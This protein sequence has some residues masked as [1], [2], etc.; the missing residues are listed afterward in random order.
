MS[1][2]ESRRWLLYAVLAAAYAL[3]SV[4]RLST[5]VLA[6][7]LQGAFDATGAELGTLHA[8]FF[9][10]YAAFQLPS[11]VVADRLG[12]RWAVAGGTV[13][14]SVGGLVFAAAASYPVAFFGRALIGFGG[15]FLFVAV[16]RFCAN[17][18]RP[19]EF[20]RMSGLTLAV[21]GLG[22]VLATTPLALVVA[23]AGWRETVSGLAALGFLVAL[24]VTLVA[25]DSPGDAGLDPVGD[26]P[27]PETPG[28]RGVARNARRVFAEPETWLA[29]A[30]LFA[31]TGVNITVFG[32]WGV[33]YVVQT[34]GLSVTGASTFTLLGSAGLLLGPPAIGYVSDRTERRT[35]LVVVGMA[36]Y[37]AA[38]AL[39]SAVGRPPLAVVGLC[40]FLAG[41]LAG[42]YAL[43]YSVIKERHAAAASGVSTGTVNTVAFAGAAVLPGAMG[44]VL[45]AY[46]TGETIG[47][48]RV[49]TTH[50][51]RVAFGLAALVSLVA[52]GC[53]VVLHRRD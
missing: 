1:R 44:L 21:A 32:L 17:W 37:A 20:A 3:V 28:L 39:L 34:Y 2:A 11:G 29:G 35:G 15:S 43:V 6:G 51:Y 13:V 42:S 7:D 24:V 36:L 46:W 31:G 45:D 16:L 14:M 5:A 41:F 53:A 52:L 12:S 47:G 18:Y 10:V 9:V 40:F 30:V 38:F 8:S 25:R 22:G 50:G 23:R 48:A 19:D 27:T 4:Y 33:P 26:L 49:Y